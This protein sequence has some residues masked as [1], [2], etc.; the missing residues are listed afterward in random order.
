M[1]RETHQHAFR[2]VEEPGNGAR[3]DIVITND[4]HGGILVVWAQA[5][6]LGRFRSTGTLMHHLAGRR[7]S[8][9]DISRIGGIVRRLGLRLEQRRS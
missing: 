2:V 8:D 7:P 1:R 4:P 6:W 3:Y 9:E 5:R